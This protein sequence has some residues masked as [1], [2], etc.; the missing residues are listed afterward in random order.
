MNNVN[1]VNNK[2]VDPIKLTFAVTSL[3]QVSLSAVYRKHVKRHIT[4]SMFQVYVAP[5]DNEVNRTVVE[6]GLLPGFLPA[7]RS[8]L[9]FLV[10][11]EAIDGQG[12]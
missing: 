11:N 12:K 3:L 1:V 7:E 5:V 6:I 9:R 2:H 10:G 4:L 8:V